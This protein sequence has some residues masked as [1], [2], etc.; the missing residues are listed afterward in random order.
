[1]MEFSSNHCGISSYHWAIDGMIFDNS[2]SAWI[3]PLMS[4]SLEQCGFQD[5]DWKTA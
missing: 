2:H 3:L 5:L 1:M 4:E